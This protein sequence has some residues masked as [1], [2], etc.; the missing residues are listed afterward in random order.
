MHRLRTV[1]VVLLAGSFAA[2]NASAQVTNTGTIQAVVVDQGNLPIPGADV[3]A[4]STD[5]V[6]KRTAVTNAAGEAMLIGLEPS[7][8]YLVVTSLAG[9][10]TQRFENVLVRSGQTTTLRMTLA[11]SGLTEQ[12]QVTAQSPIVDTKSATATT[13][14]TLQLTESLPTGRSYQSYLQ[15]VPGVLPDDPQLPGNPASKSGINYSDIGGNVGVSTDNAYYIDG[16]NVTDPQSGTFGANLNT[17]IIQEQ[18]VI[19]GGIPAE[20]VGVAGLLSNVI[21]KAGSNSYHGSANYFFQ[22]ADLQADNKNSPSQDFSTYDSAFTAGGP[23]VRDRAWAF[24]SYR[25]LHR[26]DDVTAIDTLQLL[27]TVENN[28]KQGYFKGTVA[29]TENDTFSFTFLND[30]TDITGRVERTITNARDRTRDQGGNR[31]AFNYSRLF[32]TALF[33][34]AYNRHN[35]ELSDFSKIRESSNSVLYRSTD[36]R[37][38][39]DEQRGGL[40][41]DTI[42]ERDVDGVRGAMSWVFGRHSVKG[43]VEYQRNDRFIN[44]LTIGDT[45]STYTSLANGLSGFSAN[46]IDIQSLSGSKA[47]RVSNVSDFGGLIRTINALPNRAQFYSIFDANGDGTI[48]T[49][50]FGTVALYNNT[51]GNPHSAVNY[52]RVLQSAD[53]PQ[54]FVSKGLSF[55]VQDSL[56]LG[57]RLTLNLG[58]RTERWEHFATTGENII[59]FDWAWSPRLS[60]VYDVGG[61]GRQKASAYWGRYYDPVRTNMTAFAGSLTGRTREEQLY[62]AN[63]VNQWVTYRVRGGAILDGF[64][65]PTIKTPYTDDLQLGYSIDL[66]RNMSFES[67]YNYRRTRDILEDY[68]A[69][70]YATTTSGATDYPGPIDDPNSLFLGLD[71][72]GFTVNPGANFIIAT[73]EGGERNYNGIE[74]NLRK[75]FSDNWQGIISYNYNNAKGNS[76]SDSNADFQ[77]DVIELDPRAPNNYGRQPGGIEHLF[78]LSGSYIW[79]WGLELGGNY[80]WNSGTIASRTYLSSTRNLPIQVAPADAFTFAGIRHQWIDPTAVGTLTNPSWGQVDLRVKYSTRLG[81]HLRPEVFVDMFNLFNNQDSIRNQDLVA[82]SGGIAFGQPIRYLDPRRFFVGARLNF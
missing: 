58:V 60:A 71:Y 19:T 20:Y 33:E 52:A 18:K 44:S 24:G 16:I 12:V 48:S 72:F 9:F 67:V 45:K 66:G 47:F 22:N 57:D 62:V 37:T 61:N 5:G 46:D 51:A 2:A 65:A 29:L 42:D 7:A 8:R 43:G 59:T 21:T 81:E 74:L 27:R 63:G 10:V 31:Y 30:P 49:A 26:S 35:G 15:V 6:T 3:T 38:L 32:G 68:D 76:N 23:I 50:E 4:E 79:S 78:K 25:Y 36:V 41:T 14:I 55:F 54:T 64:F 69:A 1:V 53:G 13:D 56:P 75:R 28:Q 40:G 70:L 34:A 11:V 39:S 17:E 82:G 80:R 77:G 73:L